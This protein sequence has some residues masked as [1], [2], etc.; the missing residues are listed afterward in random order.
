MDVEDAVPYNEHTRKRTFEGEGLFDSIKRQRK[1]NPNALGFS[2]AS[3]L[4]PYLEQRLTHFVEQGLGY[5]T[6]QATTRFN[7]WL[8]QPSAPNSVL[9]V[10]GSEGI[11]T[12]N[13]VVQLNK[14][15]SA[16][17][18]PKSRKGTFGSKSYTRSVNKKYGFKKSGRG[19][20]FSRR[21]RSSARSVSRGF[22]VDHYYYQT[23]SNQFTT[24]YLNNGNSLAVGPNGNVGGMANSGTTFTNGLSLGA[25]INSRLGSA[26]SMK[27]LAIRGNISTGAV[28]GNAYIP[29]ICIALVYDKEP[30]TSANLASFSQ[31]WVPDSAT[32][33]PSCLTNRDNTSRFK[34]LRRWVFMDPDPTQAPLGVNFALPNQPIFNFDAY[35]NLGGLICK[36]GNGDTTGLDVNIEMGRLALYATCTDG[37]AAGNMV[38]N[39]TARLDFDP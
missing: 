27:R 8:S 4:A 35:V 5:L 20:G 29:K 11:P 9:P 19:K 16:S 21:V 26:I 33:G 31:I 14:V 32:V 34:I 36:W 15:A 3:N 23:P 7:R 10:I 39:Y 22:P 18:M 25:G 38:F 28:A 1:E 13:Q 37:V 6:E 24:V 12:T 2:N 17:L 30:N